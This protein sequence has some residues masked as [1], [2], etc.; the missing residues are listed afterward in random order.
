MVSVP[1]YAYRLEAPV[2]AVDGDTLTLRAVATNLGGLTA[3][4]TVDV[5]IVEGWVVDGDALLAAGDL[6]QEGAAVVVASGTLTLEGSHGFRDLAVLDGAAVTQ[7]AAPATAEIPLTGLVA[8]WSFDEPADPAA[9]GHPAQLGSAAG[10]DANDPLY[11]CDAGAVARVAGNRCALD[12][13][14]DFDPAAGDYLT[15]A[16]DPVLDFTA[17]FTLS[18]WIRIDSGPERHVPIFVRGADDGSDV[19]DV[20]VFVQSLS[21]D[22]VVGVNR[23]NG[24]IFDF[25]GF[26]DPPK[27]TLFHLAI[28]F[29]GT[30]AGVYYDGVPQAL[31]QNDAVL[32]QPLA[33]GHGWLLGKVDHLQFDSGGGRQV[34]LDGLLDEVRFY[35]RALAIEE[36]SSLA[37]ATRVTLEDNLLDVTL[38]G[39]LYVACGAAIDVSGLGYRESAG[40]PNTVA[41]AAPPAVGGSHGG[42]GGNFAETVLAVPAALPGRTY[43]NLFD[44]RDPGAGGGG[45]GAGGGVIHIAALGDLVIDGALRASGGGE[46]SAAANGAGGSVRLD[47][48]AISGRGTIDAS[49]GGSASSAPGGGGG[50]VAIYAG[51]LDAG[52]LARTTATGGDS[53]DAAARGAAGTVYVRRDGDVFGELIVD[54]GAVASTQITEL[55]AVGSGAMTTATAGGFTSDDADFVHSLAGIHVVINGDLGQWWP[56][57]GHPHHGQSLDL[58]TSQL[59][60]TAQPGDTYQGL[61]QLDRV[62]VRG[63]Q[64]ATVDLLVAAVEDV[65]PGSLLEAGYQPIAELTAP[66]AGATFAAGD[67]ITITALADSV[68]GIALVRLGLSGDDVEID[69]DPITRVVVAPDVSE[70]TEM[71]VTLEIVDRS[72]RVTLDSLTVTVTP[73]APSLTAGTASQ[74]DSGHGLPPGILR[75]DEKED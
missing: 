18:G 58:D 37:A 60:F 32:P 52:L 55:L 24:G 21:Q 10:A 20:E 17:A 59:A 40:Y 53:V 45:T 16:N 3:E 11:D 54:S 1:P 56:V 2:T 43:G 14:G 7:P 13:S 6:T 42:R 36:I 75:K 62:T 41:E 31:A 51:T 73:A 66:V 26:E 49:G 25:A 9:G 27:D 67:S 70:S 47:G 48:A 61:Y 22:L 15:V 33:S 23:G 64:V 69:G 74:T 12:F 57:L 44:P 28:T 29:D 71:Q 46:G 68:F 19:N 8:A 38:S 34:F 50:R 35:D 4:T 63:A 65:E 5:R 39:D 30:T 72:G